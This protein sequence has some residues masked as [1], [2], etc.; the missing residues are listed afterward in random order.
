MRKKRKNSRRVVRTIA[1]LG[2][3]ALAQLLVSCGQSVADPNV[4]SIFFDPARAQK[5]RIDPRKQKLANV[6]QQTAAE[7]IKTTMLQGELREL[8]TQ[9]KGLERE[10]ASLDSKIAV[11]RNKRQQ[12]SAPGA[13]ER[14]RASVPAISTEERKLIARRNQISKQVSAD[15]AKLTKML[16]TR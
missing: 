3:I 15:K 16:K 7:K 13:S 1:L 4:D 10:A 6:Q 12:A 9:I 8:E 11:A 14:A 2:G 5:E